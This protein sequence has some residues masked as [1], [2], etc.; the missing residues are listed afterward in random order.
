MN[1]QDVNTFNLGN[2]NCYLIKYPDGY[3]LIDNSNTKYYQKFIEELEKRNID[4]SEIKYLL[5]THHHY[6]HAGF[7]AN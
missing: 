2:T 7:A 1:M 3:L 5:L 4:V 6:D